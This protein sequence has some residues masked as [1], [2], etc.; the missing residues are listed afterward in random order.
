MSNALLFLDI[1][2]F[3]MS[4]ALFSMGNPVMQN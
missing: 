2:L 3:F 4:D 1:V